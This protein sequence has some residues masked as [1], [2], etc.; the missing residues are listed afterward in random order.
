M[1]CELKVGDTVMEHPVYVA[2]LGSMSG[3]LGG[4]FL[5]TGAK[6]YFGLG[7]LEYNG[8]D[9][10]LLNRSQTMVATVR[11]LDAFTIKAN[12]TARF[13]ARLFN[14]V[15]FMRLDSEM[16][17]EVA[18]S[19]S[20]TRTVVVPNLIVQPK[21]NLV[22]MI[23]TNPLDKDLYIRQGTWLASVTLA[24]TVRPFQVEE[25]EGLH[26]STTESCNTSPMSD[27]L[28][29]SSDS[30]LP[31]HLELMVT[32]A[33][34]ILSPGEVKEVEQFVNSESDMFV[35]PGV[36]VGGTHLVKHYINVGR[37]ARQVKQR[38]RRLPRKKEAFVETE[39]NRLLEEKMV[40]EADGP[41]AS[42]IVLVKKGDG[43][44]RMC[45]DCRAVNDVTEKDVFPLHRIEE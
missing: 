3:V 16:L 26:M 37:R 24:K 8:Q 20:N 43:E 25:E 42:P 44:D 36:K 32:G 18:P 9:I 38:C 22:P 2:D 27:S 13:P 4:D 35:G 17:V 6:I 40:E 21:S 39:V 31:P 12:N 1:T 29:L 23:I 5:S 19:F 33:R 11:S 45:I 14:E 7:I 30:A 10:T 15:G 41:W 34:E 28:S